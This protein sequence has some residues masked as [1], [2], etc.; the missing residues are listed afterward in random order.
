MV[1]NIFFYQCSV[2]LK[3]SIIVLIWA[4]KDCHDLHIPRTTG[5]QAVV[6]SHVVG[7]PWHL[8]SSYFTL[9]YFLHS[10]TYLAYPP[11]SLPSD[12]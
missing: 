6:H 4:L 5:Y 2:V 7:R 3:P 12:H 11:R 8:F 1:S 9:L 10:L